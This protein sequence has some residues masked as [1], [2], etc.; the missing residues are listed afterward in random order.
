MVKR[1]STP[2]LN[3]VA[4]RIKR[5]TQTPGDKTALAVR[6]E[7]TPQRLNDWLSG[8]YEPG[9]EITLRLLEWVQAAEAKQQ[10]KR[11]GSGRTQPTLKTRTKR[12]SKHEKPISTG[13]A[14]KP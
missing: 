14:R 2:R 4:A 9:G 13:S 3:R 10:K 12:K 6:M 5:L 7:V 8:L 1:K 11:A